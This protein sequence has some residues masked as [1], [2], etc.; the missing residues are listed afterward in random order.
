MAGLATAYGLTNTPERRERYDVT[1]YQTGWRLGGK[2][3]SGRNEAEHGRIEEHGLHVWFGSYENA[4]TMM[5]DCYGHYRWPD[6]AP[7]RDVEGA[8]IPSDDLVL[9]DEWDD[10]WSPAMVPAKRHPGRPGDGHPLP[11]LDGVIVRIIDDVGRSR[12]AARDSDGNAADDDPGPSRWS[13]PVERIGLPLLERIARRLATSTSGRRA[14]TRGHL[15]RLERCLN[16]IR[17]WLWAH[18]A[19]PRLGRDRVRQHLTKA[20]FG[21]TLIV[22]LLADHVMANGFDALDDED[23]RAWLRRHGAS[24][25]TLQSPWVRAWYDGAFAYLDGSKRQPDIAAGTSL[26]AILRQQYGYKGAFVWKLRAGMGETVVAPIFGVL[27]DRGVR[28]EFFHRVLSI[29]LADD[30]SAVQ[31]IELDR[32]P[33]PSDFEPLTL[34]GGLRVWP[35][36]PP[37]ES[38]ADG[39]PPSDLDF[40]TGPPVGELVQLEAGVDFDV[41]VLAIPVGALPEICGELID[42]PDNRAFAEMIAASRTTMTQS[43]QLWTTTDTASLGWRY[44]GDL[45]S[46]FA[47]PL[48]TYC[49]MSHLLQWE[50]WPESDHTRGVGYFCAVSPDDGPPIT[51]PPAPAPGQLG[52]APESVVGPVVDYVEQQLTTLWPDGAGGAGGSFAWDTLVSPSNRAGAERLRDQYVRLNWA[53]GERYVLSPTSLVRRRL[54]PSQSGYPNLV[55]AGDWTKNDL[56][57][58]CVEAAVMSGLDAANA[59]AGESSP[60]DGRRHDWLGRGVPQLRPP[61]SPG[62]A[63]S[64][65]RAGAAADPATAAWSDESLDRMRQIG[66]P[67]VDAIVAELPVGASENLHAAARTDPVVRLVFDPHSGWADPGAGDPTAPVDAALGAYLADR[68]ALPSW[69]DP[70]RMELGRRFFADWGPAIAGTLFCA[71]LPAGYAAA[72]GVQVLGRT[73]ELLKRPQRRIMETGRLLITVMQDGNLEPGAPGWTDIRRVRLMHAGI[74]RMILTDQINPWDAADLGVPLNQEDLLGTLWTFSLTTID[75]LRRSGVPV[76]VD[77][78]EAYLHVW[79]VVGHLLGVGPDLLP[80]SVD[81]ARLSFDA[82]RRRQYR[83]SPEGQA[84]TRALIAL[85]RQLIG[86]RGLSGL[87]PSAIRFLAGAEVA[88]VL[89]VPRSNWTEALFLP[90]RLANLVAAES[91]RDLPL[92]AALSRWVGRHLLQ[93]VIDHDTAGGGPPFQIP[94]HL[95]DGWGLTPPAGSD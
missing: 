10:R 87:P 71:S 26:H 69:C 66:D 88:K 39:T 63:P 52:G 55:L 79:C 81:E 9:W 64:S 41:A 22:G 29:G 37:P 2:C 13:A 59:V 72:K 38:T 19:E 15:H 4:F 54:R 42:D 18:V 35:T 95:I 92:V 6:D 75:A 8:F 70:E 16:R 27:Q 43:V 28:F 45:S 1:L 80:L 57:L 34:V 23:F 44:G 78:A 21:L 61:A 94:T 86:W 90:A 46:T 93:A 20:D 84:M 89:D 5:R 49:D 47:E 30:R 7:F 62:A 12:R 3:A 24:E 53:P 83:S 60:R 14:P 67:E 40:G 68:P 48:D 77:E 50:E 11:G 56:D 58:G 33:A 76:S 74:R 17:R 51:S 82:I 25:P 91:D 31:R 73:G 85:L 65:G 32:Q 36:E